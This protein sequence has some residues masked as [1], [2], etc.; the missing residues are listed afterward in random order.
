MDSWRLLL[1]LA[2]VAFSSGSVW[3]ITVTKSSFDAI[4]GSLDANVSYASYQGGA[5]TAPGIYS[6]A[7]RLYQESS[8]NTG[9]Y[10]V[11]SVTSGYTI[12]EAKITSSMSTTTGYFIANNPGNTTPNKS[13]FVVNNHSLAANGTYTVSGLNTQHITFACFGNNSS[14]RLYVK[15]LEVTYAA[16]LTYNLTALSSNSAGG[17]VS[18]VGNTITAT[19]E[20]GYRVSSTNPYTVT[21]GATVADNGDGTFSVDATTD[22]TVQ[23]NFEAIPTYTITWSEAGATS[24]TTVYE[25]AALG[26]LPTAT[27][28]DAVNYP[29]FYGWSSSDLR[30]NIVTIAPV[31]ITSETEPSDNSTYYAVYTDGTAANYLFADMDNFANWSTTYSSKTT[32]FSDGAFI[33]LNS[34]NK[35]IQTITDIPVTKGNEVIYKAPA[36]SYIS[37]LQLNCRQWANK[38]QTIILHTSSDGVNYTQTSVTSSNFELLASGLSNVT[39]IKFTFSSQTDQIGLE[40]L[41]VH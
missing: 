27:T 38:E 5:S 20:E 12:S 9:G 34:A 13:S 8:G 7:I 19:P 24:T 1:L 30:T 22:C 6:N 31:L 18:L 10:I 25:G 28:C 17:T 4:N 29:Y 36:G 26:T 39:A 35:S 32:T 3:G 16:D 14:T 23:I 33:S 37:S 21:G 40:S 2:F 41:V 11:I 15:A